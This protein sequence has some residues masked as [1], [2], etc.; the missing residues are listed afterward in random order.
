MAN[1]SIRHALIYKKA[2]FID[3]FIDKYKSIRQ[4][5]SFPHREVATIIRL[6]F[7]G[8]NYS[9]RGALKTVHKVSSRARDLVLKTSH[10]KNIRNDQRAY[11]RL[12]ENIRNRY[13]GKIYWTTKYCLLQKYGKKSQVPPD[14]QKKLRQ[15]AK[16][17]RLIDVRKD[18]VR[19]IDG[20]FKIVDANVSKA[21]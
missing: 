14:I 18:N 21:H 9:G 8:S 6:L 15:I 13:F 5:T 11:K 3:E 1:Q 16:L 12:P 4:R 20:R 17:Y 19:R 10:P 2:K 7:P